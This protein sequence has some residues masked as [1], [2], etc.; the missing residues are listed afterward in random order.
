MLVVGF[1]GKIY[2]LPK[3]Q[4]AL[5]CVSNRDGRVVHSLG[6]TVLM[7]STMLGASAMEN[8]IRDPNENISSTMM[9]RACCLLHDI[10][11]MEQQ[12][13]RCFSMKEFTPI[14]SQDS[15]V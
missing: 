5:I 1:N 6:K 8:K 13:L 2:D 10:Q 7:G 14:I 11:S 12:T 9:R 3:F 15:G 4:I